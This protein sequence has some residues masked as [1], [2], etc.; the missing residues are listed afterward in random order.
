MYQPPPGASPTCRT[1]VPNGTRASGPTGS[2]PGPSSWPGLCACPADASRCCF[3][4]CLHG[5]LSAIAITATVSVCLCASADQLSFQS[6]SSCTPTEEGL[7]CRV[8]HRH[9]ESG[10]VSPTEACE[11]LARA[12]EGPQEEKTALPG[13][14]SWGGRQRGSAPSTDRGQCLAGVEWLSSTGGLWEDG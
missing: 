2:P 8:G 10:T 6:Q 11:D 9:P 14:V 5:H 13:E 7:K 12:L 3:H 4:S 1:C